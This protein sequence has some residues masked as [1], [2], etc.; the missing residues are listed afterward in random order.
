MSICERLFEDIEGA[1]KVLDLIAS[2]IPDM[3]F[4]PRPAARGLFIRGSDDLVLGAEL[5]EADEIY[6]AKRTVP[7]QFPHVKVYAKNGSITG[8]G[9]SGDGSMIIDSD[10]NRSLVQIKPC[11][12]DLA[13]DKVTHRP[14]Y[15]EAILDI[16]Y[17]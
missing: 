14:A 3:T 10:N 2:E 1:N 17:S 7:Y 11:T 9:A 12:S 15:Y 16:K 4:S 13:R 8:V 6:G 5:P